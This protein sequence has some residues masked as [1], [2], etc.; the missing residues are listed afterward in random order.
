M[1]EQFVEALSKWLPIQ[2]EAATRVLRITETE[3]EMFI[4]QGA[5]RVLDMLT[6]CVEEPTREFGTLWPL[7]EEAE[8]QENT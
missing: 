5:L 2:R 4:A 7:D 6:R 1:S 3:R 8:E